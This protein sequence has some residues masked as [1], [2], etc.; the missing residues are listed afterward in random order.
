MGTPYTT[1]LIYDDLFTELA[2]NHSNFHYHTA[3][4]RETRPDGRRGQYVHHYVDEQ[5]DLFGPVL[6]NPRTLLYICGLAGMQSGLY[7]VMARHGVG[8]GYFIAQ[9]ATGR[10]WI[11]ADW[12]LS[13]VRRGVRATPRCMV[14]VY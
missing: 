3:I 12:Q 2:A 7:Q 10:A 9:E 1:D 6:A 14:E 11:P 5:M 8:D 4:S 13:Q